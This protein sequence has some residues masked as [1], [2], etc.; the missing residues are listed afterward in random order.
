MESVRKYY[1]G[2]CVIKAKIRYFV[3]LNTGKHIG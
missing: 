3:Q 1:V 2:Y